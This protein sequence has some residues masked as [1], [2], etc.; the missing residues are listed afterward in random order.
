MLTTSGVKHTHPAGHTDQTIFVL[1][2]TTE[3]TYTHTS[4]NTHPNTSENTHTNIDTRAT[5]THTEVTRLYCRGLRPAES[6]QYRK[7]TET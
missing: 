1:L 2:T 5:H 3:N 6:L 4:A 7:S